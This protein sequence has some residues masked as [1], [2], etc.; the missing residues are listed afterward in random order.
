VLLTGARYTEFRCLDAAEAIESR[1]SVRTPI[2][3]VADR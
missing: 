3:P 1:S 2:D